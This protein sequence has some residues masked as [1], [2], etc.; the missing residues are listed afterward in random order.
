MKKAILSTLAVLGASSAF[1]TP[2]SA[3]VI[4]NS[5]TTGGSVTGAA[6][7]VNTPGVTSTIAAEITY[8]NLVFPT[9]GAFD[10]TTTGG[11]ATNGDLHY[12]GA[13]IAGTADTSLVVTPDATT[14]VEAAVAAE[15][16]AATGDILLQ[17]AIIRAW[18][19]GG[20]D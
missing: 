6:S 3:Q 18:R 9:D 4:V 17:P 12:L 13:T 14:S 5:T 8:P 19:S 7:V 11:D 1:I 15:I 2:A 20:L 10:V 16:T